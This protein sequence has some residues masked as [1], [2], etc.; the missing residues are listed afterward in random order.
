[1][2]NCVLD[3]GCLSY[4]PDPAKLARA[5]ASIRENTVSPY[6]LHVVHNPSE[7]DEETVRYVSSLPI[8]YVGTDM[9]VTSHFLP[10]NEG[11]A[12]GVNYLFDFATSDY[13]AYCDNDIEIRTHGWDVK[14]LDVLDAHPEVGQVFPGVGHYGF[15][16][17]GYHECLWNAG[18]CWMLRR[19]SF[20]KLVKS[21]TLH[22]RAPVPGL[23]DTSLGHHEEVDLMIRLRLA[24]YRIAACPDVDVFHNETATKAN[25]ADHKPGGRIHDGVV[26][27]MNKWNRYFCGDQLEYSMTA[28]DPRALRYTDWN[29]DALYL[30]RMTL[31]YFPEW[32][33][34]PET[35]MVPGV[36]EMHAVKVLKPKGPYAHRAI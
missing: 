18:Y 2:N 20:S 7:G 27:W 31:A 28:Y 16:N 22:N 3:I 25:E 8:Q 32:N 36:G 14:M 23:L 6:R 19:E 26:R 4:G 9:R 12:G 13:I 33:G 1:M 15:H 5:I 29:V 10:R 34:E 17:G 35:V 24:G 11:Y 30:E 21:D